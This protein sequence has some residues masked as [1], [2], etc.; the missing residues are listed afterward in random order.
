MVYKY[1][2]DCDIHSVYACRSQIKF[3]KKSKSE[4]D[5]HGI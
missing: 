5:T 4:Y 3:K 1:E 2:H